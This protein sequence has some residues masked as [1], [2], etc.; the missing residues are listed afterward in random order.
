MLSRLEQT[1]Y[2]VKVVPFRVPPRLLQLVL[3]GVP[4]R[5]LAAHRRLLSMFGRVR[6][7]AERWSLVHDRQLALKLVRDYKNQLR[8]VY[9]V[10][11][12]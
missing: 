6:R 11:P 5:P 10:K 2:P 8:S 7:L 9:Y 3:L 12:E 4:L 1:A